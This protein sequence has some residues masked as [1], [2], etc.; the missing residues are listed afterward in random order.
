MLIQLSKSS[1]SERFAPVANLLNE[2]NQTAIDL[3]PGSD[4]LAK[5]KLD[6][7]GLKTYDVDFRKHCC[8][9]DREP[10]WLG[11]LLIGC[12]LGSVAAVTAMALGANQ[13][14][15]FSLHIAA[16]VCATMTV[17]ALKLI[18]PIFT[19]RTCNLCQE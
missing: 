17:F 14:S 6:L 8:E 1:S 16:T 18:R 13:W 15:V 12:S 10:R 2:L 3:Q 4:G 5:C 19:H 9:I 11:P 7:Y